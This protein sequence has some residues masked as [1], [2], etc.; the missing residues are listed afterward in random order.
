MTKKS[1]K[2][3]SKSITWKKTWDFIWHSNSP[4]SWL[5]NVL[6]AFLIIKFLIYPALGAVFGTDLPIVAVISNS[7]EHKFQDIPI[8]A[9]GITV[10]YEY[11]MCG[12][13]FQNKEYVDYDYWWSKCGDWYEE[14]NISKDIFKEYSF[15]TGFNTGDLMIIVNSEFETTQVGDVI[16]FYR[17][18]EDR[19]TIPIIHRV[20]E[21]VDN[22][23][24]RY[25][26]TKGDNNADHGVF[27]NLN[28]NFIASNTVAGKAVAR[29][30]WLGWVKIGFTNLINLII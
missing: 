8:Q 15:S 4:W 14:R 19:T 11:K 22:K 9:N 25:Y 16:V 24:L 2:S 18:A 12:K 26:K 10:G 5:I 3:T 27:S 17:Q 28:E 29:I 7:M 1:V 6:L 21:K 30:P 13:L 20:V 23:G